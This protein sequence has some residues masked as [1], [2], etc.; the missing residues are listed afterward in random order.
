MHPFVNVTE[1]DQRSM[2][3]ADVVNAY[4]QG[5]INGETYVWTDGMGDWLPLGQVDAIVAR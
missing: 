4:N 5:I 3:V 1:G 2:A